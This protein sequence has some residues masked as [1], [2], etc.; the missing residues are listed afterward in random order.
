MDH[1]E[2]L[3]AMGFLKKL[4]GFSMASWLCAGISFLATPVLTR[5]Y[6]PEEI[7]HINIFSTYMTFFQTISIMALDQAFMRFYNEPLEGVNKKNFL[8]YCLRLNLRLAF[9]F[10]IVICG[11]FGYFSTQISGERNLLIPVCLSIVIFCSTFLRM[12]SISSRMERNIVQYTWQVILIVFIEKIIV[13]FTAFIHPL[14]TTA[15]FTMTVCY[16]IL[17]VI[18]FYLKREVLQPAEK[19]PRETV[20]AI[21]KYSLPY[22]PVLLLSWL[23]G[24]IP[25]LVLRKYMDYSTIGIYTN[26]V[27]MASILTIAQ[28]GFSA[29][30]EPFIF[31]HFRDSGS[32]HKIE[33]IQRV[34]IYTIISIAISIVLFQDMLY[35]LVGEKFRAS[36]LIFPLL[37]FTPICN[38]IA[39]MTGVGVKIS[40][41]NYLNIY[42]FIGNSLT[43][44]CLSYLLVP[45]I[46]LMGAGIAVCISSLVMLIIRSVLGARYYKTDQNY[47]HIIVSVAL[48]CAACI[49]NIFFAGLIYIRTMTLL[50]I[51]VGVCL[52]F[53]TEM[54][55]IIKFIV[56]EIRTS[57]DKMNRN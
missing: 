13:A 3:T 37:M 31:E 51:L 40:K 19:I 4:I 11:G 34:I 53:K 41:K 7:G 43:N 47:I 42:A 24:S 56:C 52:L 49:I 48:M 20:A 54:V 44:I 29:Y 50:L 32:K 38:S 12:S 5:M 30:W 6:L 16:V 1:S 35:L 2:E 9:V 25:L 39:D 23:N 8:R 27:T 26:A 22:V 21:F 15:I 10:A 33:K 46:G 36:K 17:S 45:T 57:A 55:T 14:H 28:T 18:F